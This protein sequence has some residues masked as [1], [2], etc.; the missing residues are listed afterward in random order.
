MT[1]EEF[2]QSEG[3][4]EG[5]VEYKAAKAVWNKGIDNKL[6]SLPVANKEARIELQQSRVIE[7]IDYENAENVDLSGLEGNPNSTGPRVTDEDRKNAKPYPRHL[8]D[9]RYR[10]L[11][12]MNN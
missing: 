8:I 11:T 7:H 5:S 3:I 12:G 4:E 6:A 1:F 2:C 10:E 9:D